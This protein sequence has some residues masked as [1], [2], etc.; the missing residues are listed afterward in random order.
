MPKY[1]TKIWHRVLVFLHLSPLSLAEK[2]RFAFAAAVLFILLVTLLVAYM[3]MGKLTINASLYAG[4][5]RAQML[6]RQHFKLN[7]TAEAA[8]AALDQTGKALSDIDR[9]L[10]WI[11]LTEDNVKEL[12]ALSEKQRKTIESLKANRTRDDNIFFIRDGKVLKS[13][14]IKIFRASESCMDCHNR[15]GSA[16]A[17]S[18]NEP[19]GALVVSRSADEISKTILLT[20]VWLIAAFLIAGAGAIVA[21]YWITQRVILRPVRQLRA[22]ANNVAEGNLK[23]RSAIKTRDEYEKL[24]EAFNHMLDSLEATQEKLR[25]ANKQ[26]DDKIAELSQ[27]NIELFKA[28]KI[29]SEFLAN[30]S[31]EFRTP[32]NGILGFA[33]ILRE[34]PGLLAKEKGQ[35]YAENII[36]S[37]K[38]LLNMVNDLLDLAKTEAGKMELHIEQASLVQLCKEI[39]GSFAAIT[40]NKKIKVKSVIDKNIPTLTTDVGKV[41][42][43]MYNFLSNAVK[44]TPESG[45]VEINAKMLDEKTVRISVCD[46]GPGIAEADQEKLFEKFRQLDGSITR[47]SPGSGL[48]LAIC[49][50]LSALLAGTVG[51]QSEPGKGSTFWLDIPVTL[52]KE[53]KESVADI[54]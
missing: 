21:F 49:Q 6:L 2:C 18:L 47:Q 46:T 42:Q 10:R 51:M 33:E 29:K 19:V 26:L 3:W 1:I 15:Q 52:I 39:V 43:V 30:V 53:G 27:R 32:L 17:F 48:G 4:R 16:S 44:F 50:E 41:R 31:H 9:Q 20:R 38:N 12:E 22:L 34:K 45:R 14:Y 23:V 24:A 37:G 54:T 35:R 40:R 36:A 11:R 5:A 25:Q 28:N 7:D 8:P 13:N